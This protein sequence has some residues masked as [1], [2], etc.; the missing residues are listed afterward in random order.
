VAS[1]RKR[2]SARRRRRGGRHKQ[3]RQRPLGLPL[4]AV[5]SVLMAAP[6]GHI[7][8]TGQSS[9]NQT[10]DEDG[11]TNLASTPVP[12]IDRTDQMRQ[13]QAVAARAQAHK[14]IARAR[15]ERLRRLAEKRREAAQRAARERAR[16]R[17]VLPIH[18]FTL[19]AGFGE[20]SSLWHTVHTGQDFAAP[21]GTPVYSVGT[22]R[23]I[24]AGWAGDYGYRIEVQH[25][26]GTVSWYCHLSEMIHT[27]GPVSPGELIGRVGDTGNT[28]GPH[29]HLEI[30]PHGDDAVDPMA[31]LH[32]RGLI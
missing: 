6:A 21:T 24:S 3:A 22:G 16:K 1:A 8:L 31:W 17:W 7:A 9:F 28:T 15:A 11:A 12:D 27:S 2:S 18:H 26:D 23:V 25:W 5:A 14:E 32:D 30:H 29:L 10:G 4:V 19:T 13:D 20:V